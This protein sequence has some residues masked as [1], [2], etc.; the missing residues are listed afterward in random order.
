MVVWFNP[1]K[2][3]KHTVLVL[4]VFFD[5]VPKM[6][7]FLVFFHGLLKRTFYGTSTILLN[8]FF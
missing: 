3:V 1:V 2:Y 5:E 8:P 4:Q 7:G 6:S